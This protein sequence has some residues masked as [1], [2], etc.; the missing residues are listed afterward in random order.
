MYS[1]QRAVR[2]FARR[3]SVRV[4][5]KAHCASPRLSWLAGERSRAPGAETH[6][7]EGRGGTARSQGHS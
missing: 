6:S 4:G 7:R 1:K 5:D 2:V 3:F